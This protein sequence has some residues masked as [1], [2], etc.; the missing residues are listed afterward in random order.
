MITLII[1]QTLKNSSVQFRQIDSAVDQLI[2][3]LSSSR[4]YSVNGLTSV[5]T[6]QFDSLEQYTTYVTNAT[7]VSFNTQQSINAATDG[8]RL[9]VEVYETN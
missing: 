7:I 1:T 8:T 2:S 3:S 6:L 5:V 9:V 4:D